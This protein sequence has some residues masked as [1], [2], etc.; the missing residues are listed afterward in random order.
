MSKRFVFY[1]EASPV[2]HQ[3]ILWALNEEIPKSISGW[4]NLKIIFSELVLVWTVV[5]RETTHSTPCYETYEKLKIL[6]IANRNTNRL[7]IHHLKLDYPNLILYV[8]VDNCTYC[9]RFY[10]NVCK[11]E[12][13]RCNLHFFFLRSRTRGIL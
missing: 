7:M 11:I 10:F 5:A 2:V 3:F 13:I 6:N 8:D 12:L 1:L 4:T 9:Y